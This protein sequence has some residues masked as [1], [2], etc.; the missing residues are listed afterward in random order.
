[1]SIECDTS[2]F[3]SICFVPV[4]PLLLLLLLLNR[5]VSFSKSPFPFRATQSHTRTTQ[6]TWS[7]SE[8]LA[9]CHINV[10]NW[11]CAFVQADRCVLGH[12]CVY[13]CVLVEDIKWILLEIPLA[14]FCCCFCCCCCCGNCYCLSLS[15]VIWDFCWHNCI[16]HMVVVIQLDTFKCH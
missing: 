6:Y 9:Y 14:T 15:L 7:L 16:L 12:A 11:Y 1:M 2:N 8:N 13:E 10:V 4:F 5:F 3:C